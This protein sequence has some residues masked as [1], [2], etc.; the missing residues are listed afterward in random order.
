MLLFVVVSSIF[1]VLLCNFRPVPIT[2]PLHLINKALE[3]IDIGE[4]PINWTGYFARYRNNYFLTVCFVWFF[5]FLF[6][7]GIKDIWLPLYLASVAGIMLS[8]VFTWLVAVRTG[9]M[10]AGLKVLMLCTINPVYYLLPFWTYSA[11]FGMPLIMGVL[12]F[13]I[14]IWQSKSIRQE[15]CYCT[16]VA[17]FSVLG[18]F[19]RPTSVI[20]LIALA[21]CMVMFAAKRCN[22]KR[23]LRCGIVCMFIAVVL[24]QSISSVTHRYFSTVEAGNF[25]I[26]HWLMTASHGTGR[27]N[28]EDDTYTDSFETKK[29]KSS[30]TLKKA[31]QNYKELGIAEFVKF[32]Y[33][34]MLITWAYGDANL[35]GR[36][37]QERN[38]GR[39]YDWIAGDKDDVFRLY[40]QAFRMAM[41]FLIAISC[42]S[43]LRNRRIDQYNFLFALSLFGG[44]LFYCFW[45]VKESYSVPFIYIMFLIACY[46]A[47]ILQRNVPIISEMVCS[48]KQKMVVV[49]VFAG[50]MFL[51]ILLYHGLSVVN[52]K[53]KDYSVRSASTLTRGG[54]DTGV[55]EETIEQEFYARKTFNK[56]RLYVTAD[57]EGTC[58]Y[59]VSLLDEN[60]NELYS[61]TISSKGIKGSK[62][63]TVSTGEIQPNGKQKY[64]VRLVRQKES[65]G[66]L[67]FSYRSTPYV[68]MYDGVCIV[69]NEELPYDLL[70]Q[71]YYQQTKPFCSRKIGILISG[72]LF[73]AVLLMYLWMRNIFRSNQHLT[74]K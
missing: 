42:I 36:M 45:E 68:D 1:G 14:C 51:C 38:I 57:G 8:T 70:L 35:G 29:E 59:R 32:E 26:G 71:V 10:R 69:N 46:G 34:K 33:D 2:D 4:I 12:Y 17:L 25:P 20:P 74:D 18:Y 62:Y 73:V 43:L 72:G 50:L 60:G 39:L 19:I 65:E 64:T 30:E 58:I 23:M 54:I 16:A 21:V 53:Q 27:C 9:G 11:S 52:I 28:T 15:I 6:F 7:L 49:S 67:I 44:I 31:A 47:N 48:R 13:G 22:V 37:A 3:I 56:I 40:C 66:K 24:F 55:S 5:K 41:L 63:V 61:E